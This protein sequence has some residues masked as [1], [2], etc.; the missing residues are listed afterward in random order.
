VG[1][2]EKFDNIF[3]SIEMFAMLAFEVHKGPIGLFA[4]SLYFKGRD[5][6][7]FT[8]PLLER[9]KVTLSETVYLVDYGASYVFGPWDVGK[10]VSLTVEPYGG[11]RFFNDNLKL[12][13]HP[14]SLGAG[15]R[16]RDT[17]RFNT[18][19][20]G[21]RTHWDITDRSTLHVAGDRGGWDVDD[22]KK[23]YQWYATVD[24][25]FKIRELSSRVFAGYRE[26]HVHYEKSAD[27]HVWIRGPVIGIGFEF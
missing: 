11:F 7:R 4:N 15:F 17:L 12:E 13:L 19:I 2:P 25:R 22:V 14:D 16:F 6:E 27:I 10:N 3:D 21:V 23:T 20:V 26:L 8:G 5:D 9:R 18:P 1:L 24:Y